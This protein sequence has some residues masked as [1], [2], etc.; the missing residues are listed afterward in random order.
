MAWKSTGKIA[1]GAT[2]DRLWREGTLTEENLT[3]EKA[4][5]IMAHRENWKAGDFVSGAIQ[6]AG[7]M[8]AQGVESL[9]R[10]MASPS[11][12]P[13]AVLEGGV[14][15]T[16]DL[17]QQARDLKGSWWDDPRRIKQGEDPGA[18]YRER[19]IEQRR[20]ESEQ[21]LRS[22]RSDQGWVSDMVT[23]AASQLGMA[24]ENAA[25][26]GEKFA[27]D[28]QISETVA[29]VADA[30]SLVPA[31][32]VAGLGRKAAQARRAA[33]AADAA[34]KAAEHATAVKAAH[35][36]GQA[37]LKAAL[38]AHQ[39]AKATAEM[40][41]DAARGVVNQPPG[42]LGKAA[43][44][45]GRAAGAVGQALEDLVPAVE[46]LDKPL[47]V[48]QAVGGAAALS[49]IN[50][51][52]AAGG[53]AAAGLGRAS[54]GL[55]RAA[56]VASK[57]G[58]SL[59]ALAKTDPASR[60][61]VWL[62]IAK[63]P[64]AP[65][66]LKRAAASPLGAAA[67]VATR[68]GGDVAKGAAIGAGIGAGLAGLDLNRGAEDVG[69]AA[70]AGSMLGAGG[71]AAGRALSTSARRRAQLAHDKLVAV[72]KAITNGARPDRVFAAPDD[73]LT[74]AVT[75]EKLFR[76]AM[77]GGQDLNILLLDS[78]AYRARTGG[79]P[80]TTQVAEFIPEE[81]TVLVNVDYR[82]PNG[83]LLHEAVGHALMSSVVANNPDIVA[84]FDAV[85]SPVDIARAKRL[86]A[87]QLGLRGQNLRDYVAA[88]D[89][90][91]PQWIYGEL[92]AD[93]ASLVLRDADVLGDT[94]RIFGRPAKNQSSLFS[95]NQKLQR[96]FNDPM[97][98]DALGRS[99]KALREYLPG[100]G[101]KETAP[102][103]A[104][105]RAEYV[106]QH[107]AYPIQDLG[108]FG[109][110]ND[111]FAVTDTGRVVQRPT[112]QIRRIRRS[113]VKEAEAMAPSNAPIAPH[114]DKDPTLKRRQTPGGRVERTGTKM[115]RQFYENEN[116][117][118]GSIRQT[119]L[120]LEGAIER[121]EARQGWYHQIGEGEGADY[122]ASV[123]RELGNLE[124]QHKE[125]IPVNFHLTN[126][127]NLN[128]R[129]YSLSAFDRKAREWAGRTGR[130]LSLDLWDGSVDGFRGDVRTYLE[131]HRNG[132]PGETG[133]GQ[134]K[135]DLINAFLIGGHRAF[136]DKNPLRAKLGGKDRTGII[137]SYR[138]ERLA[139]NDP[140]D[141]GMQ[142]PDH[143]KQLQNLSPAEP[144]LPAPDAATMPAFFA[145]DKKGKVQL[146]KKTKQPVVTTTDYAFLHGPLVESIIQAEP[147]PAAA[148]NL[149]FGRGGVT[150]ILNTA[151]LDNRKPFSPEQQAL[152]DK[153][154]DRYSDVAEMDFRR[155]A[156]EKDVMNAIG[157]YSHVA[158][159]VRGIL[160]DREDRF[161]F[162][163]FLGGTS[164]N[165]SVEQ[166]FLYA[167]DLFNRWKNGEL[168]KHVPAWDRLNAEHASGELF[169]RYTTET[170]A[171]AKAREKNPKKKA[172]YKWKSLG[173][174]NRFIDEFARMT[175][176]E[177][178]GAKKLASER[179]KARERA[180]DPTPADILSW[181]LFVD[182]AIPVRKNGGKYGVHTDRVFQIMARTWE[183]DTPAPKAPNFTGNLKGTRR[184]ATIDVWAA[185]F[186]R[187]LGY[188]LPGAGPWRIQPKA[189]PGV[190]NADFFFG[191]DV[192]DAAVRKIGERQG[193][194]MFADDLQAVMWFAEKK[195]WERRG[196]SK[197]AD[198]GDFRDY[199]YK[200]RQ[201]PVT[202]SLALE[203][204]TLGS[205]SRGFFDSLKF[206]SKGVR[207]PTEEVPTKLKRARARLK[208]AQADLAAAADEAAKD[209]VK[210]RI[211]TI[212]KLKADLEKA[213]AEDGPTQV[214]MTRGYE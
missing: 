167:I 197:A 98:R 110:G 190:G 94:D 48:A 30:S 17:G 51:F 154:V 114:T 70:G 33:V 195:E 72:D 142:R 65:A 120:D 82:D 104:P 68:A 29:A 147:D 101:A 160:P 45:V 161:M 173:D 164:P 181:R 208:V 155:W 136:E 171:S 18:V 159:K 185:R 203:D 22:T 212:E 152:Y 67:E 149:L 122:R 119:A 28:P 129:V 47:R 200:M 125:F 63:D 10:G 211:K 1:D 24:P 116:S 166:N 16:L 102:K 163:E 3:P 179:A 193:V 75:L 8:F 138:L 85:L 27:A 214:L 53:G 88:Q 2:L 50:I 86:Y 106:G 11:S 91:D 76:G 189:E 109:K 205:T 81:S 180:Q 175:A 132:L 58:Q 111:W 97:V 89:A 38:D 42:M 174:R 135:R 35:K 192:F 20:V 99:F 74:N 191:Q 127:N 59:E 9:R 183:R 121:G 140:F 108:P 36:A 207:L 6:G 15:G 113:R 107:P 56:A 46:K 168:Q 146:D 7:H 177:G 78:D 90:R 128:V 198:L 34:R 130:E 134:Q 158:D 115:P 103:G 52:L 84:A 148:R 49:P 32:A 202:G 188:E 187:R 83:R 4:S 184:T 153:I 170:A 14:R 21:A 92:A 40:A 57:F 199:L 19:L 61:P 151:H 37:P 39:T 209:R 210:A 55:E 150:T 126:K 157:W 69:A 23:L 12:V 133:I 145:R 137:R 176:G 196:W 141:A 182:G 26:L 178:A 165:T 79:R 95:Q 87:L 73:V 43:G 143:G 112:S 144:D 156:S 118:Y 105:M 204:A 41:A 31:G 71:A 13:A 117:S 44:A 77:P 169:E 96:S 80:D 60:A 194:Q 123:A 201:D 172:A 66:W 5:A 62:Q 139:T 93:S 25:A 124:A 213:L 206:P 100:V 186:L 131:N 64:D 54:R 162:L